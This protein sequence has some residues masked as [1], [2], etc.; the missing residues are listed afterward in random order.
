VSN[1]FCV[2]LLAAALRGR[3]QAHAV[4]ADGR[5]ATVTNDDGLAVR[6]E[7][8][9]NCRFTDGVVAPAD[10][11]TVDSLR[12][13]RVLTDDLEIVAPDGGEFS[14]RIVLP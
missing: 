13:H 9:P 6:L 14:Y 3:R 7:L 5:S 1:E 12:L 8:G 2:D 10:A 4:A 11:P